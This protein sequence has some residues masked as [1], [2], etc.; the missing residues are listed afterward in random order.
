MLKGCSFFCCSPADHTPF[1]VGKIFESIAR[2]GRPTETRL[3]RV[4]IDL[5]PSPTRWIWLGYLRRGGLL[6][7]ENGIDWC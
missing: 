4:R 3:F 6:G 7:A 2:I 1:N 5:V